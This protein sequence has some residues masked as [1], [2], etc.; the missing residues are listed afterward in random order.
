MRRYAY[1]AQLLLLA[2][3]LLF[4]S[5]CNLPQKSPTASRTVTNPAAGRTP[6]A[7]QTL[8]P[9]SD[10]LPAGAALTATPAEQQTAPPTTPAAATTVTQAAVYPDS[11][12]GV[13]QAFIDAYPDDTSTMLQYLSTS[14][15]A[16]LPTGG[17]GELL[18]VLGDINGF[19]ILSGSTV[20]Q[21]PQAEIQGAFQVGV[22]QALRTFYLVQENG[23]WVITSIQ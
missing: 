20:P 16:S 15:K 10:T 22:Q 13:V 23:R 8:Q 3:A 2:A 9:P 19:V 4:L 1:C 12:E 6:F 18:K 21:P 5:A 17:P 7:L 11:P 14:L